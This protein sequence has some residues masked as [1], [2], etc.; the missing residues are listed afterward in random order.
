MGTCLQASAKDRLVLVQVLIHGG[1][2]G[3]CGEGKVDIRRLD[4]LGAK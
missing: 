3:E 1:D 2:V 4:D